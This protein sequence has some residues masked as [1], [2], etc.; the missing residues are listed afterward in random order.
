M[1]SVLSH[2]PSFL[3]ACAGGMIANL[4]NLPIPWLL[5]SLF[6]VGCASLFGLPIKTASFGRKAGVMVIG[7]SLGLYFT[8]Q[9][10]ALL[11]QYAYLMIAVALFSILLGVIG[12][13]I[14]YRF[15]GVSFK[16]AWFA[17][18][19]GG[20]SEMSNFAQIHGARVDQVVAAHSLRV[21]MV[22]TIVPFFYKFMGYHG[23][24][25]TLFS[26][27]QTI[28]I[29][30]LMILIGLSVV[31][32]LIFERLK[33]SNPWTFAPLL[34]TAVLTA[35]DLHLSAMPSYLSCLGQICIGWTLGAK[36]RPDFFQTAPKLL[37][38]TALSVVIHLILTVIISLSLAHLMGMDVSILGLGFAPGGVAEMTITAKTLQLGVPIV[39][40]LHVVRMMAVIG[41]AG[42]LYH[43]INRQFIS[44]QDSR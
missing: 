4:L 22:V 39:T 28:D 25:N 31:A 41:S 13:A 38:A 23:D 20:A 24:H 5:G 44:P 1:F 30:G 7:I 37:V 26:P 35:N 18:V 34:T 15:G 16:T 9:M 32:A 40:M 36:F 3:I 10:V 19:I 21:L 29:S 12:S 11:H 27:N 43:W 8:P 17:S 14:V 42:V 33:W 6:A 2:L